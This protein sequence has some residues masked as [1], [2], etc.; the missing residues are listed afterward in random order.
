MNIDNRTIERRRLDDSIRQDVELNGS[1][2]S[3]LSREKQ[4]NL[5]A[6]AWRNKIRVNHSC[7][8]NLFHCFC[9]DWLCVICSDSCNCAMSDGSPR[10]GDEKQ[11]L[12]KDRIANILFYAMRWSDQDS[13]RL[14]DEAIFI[15]GV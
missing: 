7:D 15:V 13:D 6:K 4:N 9:G 12:L 11:E 8:A 10:F 3:K 1:T 5:I 14:F 2:F